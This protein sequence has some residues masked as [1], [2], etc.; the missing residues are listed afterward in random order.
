MKVSELLRWF[1]FLFFGLYLLLLRM[2]G[3]VVS[4]F[5]FVS[6]NMLTFSYYPS[7]TRSGSLRTCVYEG[8]REASF[9]NTSVTDISELISADI[10][11]TTYDVLKADLSHD[12]DRHEGDRRLMRFQKRFCQNLWHS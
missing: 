7:H 8:V 12:S 11:L 10:V 6:Q 5:F 1:I 9:S 4:V 2:V 3:D